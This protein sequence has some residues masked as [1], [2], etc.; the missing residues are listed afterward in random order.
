MRLTGIVH[1]KEF[2]DGDYHGL[3]VS[4]QA[5]VVGGSGTEIP[6]PRGFSEPLTKLS[7]TV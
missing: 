4:F 6:E 3:G 2:L 1:F 7:V 5:E